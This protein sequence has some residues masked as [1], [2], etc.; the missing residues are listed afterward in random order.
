MV[1]VVR[2]HSTNTHT[3]EK[4]NKT[5]KRRERE[6]ERRRATAHIEIETL[7]VCER[8]KLWCDNFQWAIEGQVVRQGPPSDV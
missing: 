2:Q 1:S 4:Q 7:Y 8:D 3:H 6:R 5:K